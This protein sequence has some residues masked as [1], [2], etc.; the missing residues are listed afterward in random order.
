[1]KLYIN[2]ITK[3]EKFKLTN[4]V[5]IRCN[6][7]ELKE[8]TSFFVDTLEVLSKMDTKGLFPH[9]HYKDFLN[10]GDS[11]IT[12]IIVVLDENENSEIT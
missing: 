2:K 11:K 10:K 12:D 6:I 4:E 1:M 3:Q 7:E 5:T 8:I 9:S